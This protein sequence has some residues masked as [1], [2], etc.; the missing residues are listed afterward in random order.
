MD[1]RYLKTLVT[2]VETGSFSKAAEELHLTQSAVSQ[3]V[4]FLEERFGHK[5]IDSS[6]AQLALTSAGELVLDSAQ[7]VLAIQDRLIK[8]LQR[9]HSKQRISLC[10]TPTFGTVFLP[11][12]LNVFMMENSSAVDLKFLF[13][14]PDDAIEGVR[15]HE[16]DLAV[17]EHCSESDLGAFN[18]FALPDDQLAFVSSPGLGLPAPEL[19][20]DT[21]LNM[22][23]LSRKDGCSSKQLVR[24]GL[25]GFGKQLEDF[26]GVVTSDDLHLTC[27]TVMAGGGVSFMSKD[28]VKDYLKSGQMIAHHVEGFTHQRNRSVILNRER[29]NDPLVRSFVNCIF[30][31]LNRPLPFEQA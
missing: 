16:F 10:C 13:N 22:R 3:R 21:L 19:D 18:T 1:T 4:K 9:L 23:L 28:M 12:V 14:S 17:I 25:A 20:L 29:T 24:A 6:G 31:V 30:S 7:R 26:N 5:L 8:D 27:Q 2:T 11:A 15:N